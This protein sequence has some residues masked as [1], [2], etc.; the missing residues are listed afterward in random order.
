MLKQRVITAIILAVCFLLALFALPA[1]AFAVFLG[2]VAA[3]C[4]R[5]W[6]DISA[7]TAGGAAKA[8][9]IAAF[10]LAGLALLLLAG[11]E[12][13][14]RFVL[15][16]AG[17]WWLIVVLVMYL[18]PVA[19]KPASGGSPFYLAAG[20]VSVLPAMLAAYFLRDGQVGSP[21]LLLY[22]FAVVWV[23]DIGAYFSGKRFGKHKLA[24]SISPGKTIEG[25]LGGALA[26]LL[27]WLICAFVL[28]PADAVLSPLT[29][30]LGTLLA[31]PVS[32]V[33]DLFESRAKRMAGMKDSGTLLPGHGGML[34]RLDSAFAALPVFAFAMYWL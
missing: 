15:L 2:L 1:A 5:E 22:A 23:M 19:Q 29:L 34:D 3:L 6:Y 30:L 25:V 16:G 31:A 17:L 12:P 10:P 26:T 4:A 20:F 28:L 33:G 24:P 7:A 27:F 13:V 21:W 11:S 14:L 8:L 9:Y 32:V 18:Q